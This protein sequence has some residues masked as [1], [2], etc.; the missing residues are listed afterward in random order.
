MRTN[1]IDG[2]LAALRGWL[3]LERKK[4]GTVIYIDELE[5][6]L[7]IGVNEEFDGDAEYLPFYDT[8][9]GP[10]DAEDVLG[11]EE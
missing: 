8:E 11:A 9:D 6:I 5:A 2:R 4:Q 3:N 7:G 10:A 1:E